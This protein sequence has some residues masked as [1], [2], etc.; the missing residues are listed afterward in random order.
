M[1]DDKPLRPRNCGLPQ[2]EP[3]RAWGRL[4]GRIRTREQIPETRGRGFSEN[5]ENT[6]KGQRFTGTAV[7]P[8]AAIRPPLRRPVGSSE[9]G[10]ASRS[11]RSGAHL[12]LAW[13]R[14]PWARL[15]V[16]DVQSSYNVSFSASELMLVPYFS[17][18][19]L[20]RCILHL[21]RQ[22]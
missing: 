10:P 7:G 4:A 6:G 17:G 18:I 22:G 3:R 1:G 15:W 2:G 9:T 16:V 14:P 21:C 12:M 8:N 19:L 11:R 5:L 13:P 20:S